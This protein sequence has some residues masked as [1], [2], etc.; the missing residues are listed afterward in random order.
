MAKCD[1]LSRLGVN[2]DGA[3]SLGMPKYSDGSVIYNGIGKGQLANILP[4]P[5]QLQNAESLTNDLLNSAKE[6]T[7]GLSRG[8][9]LSSGQKALLSR[10]TTVRV[11]LGTNADESC[12]TKQSKGPDPN[13]YYDPI[14]HQL[15]ICPATARLARPQLMMLMAHEIGHVISPCAMGKSFY[16][17]TLRARDRRAIEQCFGGAKTQLSIAS[18]YLAGGR[19]MVVNPPQMLR[20]P[21]KETVSKLAE[22]GFIRP[23][24]GEGNFSEIESYG[25]VTQCLK[26][27]YSGTFEEFRRSLSARPLTP[28]DPLESSPEVKCLGAFEEHFAEA[29]GAKLFGKALETTTNQAETA[30]VGLTQMTSY[31]CGAKANSKPSPPEVRFQYPRSADRLHVQMADP[32]VQAALN[33]QTP[34]STICT[35]D[36]VR[37]SEA[38]LQTSQRQESAA[39]GRN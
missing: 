17:V 8:D 38:G 23:R 35:F 14:W 4:T 39:A 33:C 15:V 19:Y 37:T 20:T 1:D 9:Q 36:P 13:A 29:F 32:A 16:D 26:H 25:Q 7:S 21:Y 24:T 6:I 34:V 5:A 27:S 30:K 2:I 12:K 10:L 22:C 11:R 31:A 18:D 28:S 3:T